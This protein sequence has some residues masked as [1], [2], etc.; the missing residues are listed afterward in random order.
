MARLADAGGRARAA[1]FGSGDMPMNPLILNL[2]FLSEEEAKA[3]AGQVLALR[4]RWLSRGYRFST[5][6]VAAYL[7]VQNTDDPDGQYYARL[8]EHNGLLLREFGWLLDRL[9]AVLAGHFDKR[10][11][12]EPAVALPGFHIFEH[13][14]IP[15]FDQEGHHFD[16]QHRALRFPFPAPDDGILSFTLALEL[17]ERGG[18]LDIWQVTERDMWRYQRMGRIPNANLIGRTKPMI[19]HHY[20]IGKMAVLLRPVL[21]RIAAVPGTVEGDRRI[22]LQGHC[23][24]D[25]DTLVLYW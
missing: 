2:D 11:R 18:G 12:F 5:L 20:S 19:R 24:R 7:D 8:E 17:P 1:A 22:T 9:L 6:G 23:V 13:G 4:G 15:I 21:H 16:L 25:G 14:G 10:T 3:A